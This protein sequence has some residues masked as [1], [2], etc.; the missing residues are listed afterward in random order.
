MEKIIWQATWE[1][2]RRVPSCSQVVTYR[3]TPLKRALCKESGQTEP[4]RDGDAGGDQER[5]YHEKSSSV[6]GGKRLGLQDGDCNGA[7]ANATAADDASDEP[8]GPG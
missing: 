7:E 6:A 4:A 8:G 2:M 1:M 5:L 3:E